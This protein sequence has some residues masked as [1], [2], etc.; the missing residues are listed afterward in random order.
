MSGPH[1][2]NLKEIFHG[3]AALPLRERAA[4]LDQACDGNESIRVA[5]ESLLKAHEES[6]NFVDAPAYLA[7]AD[8]LTDDQEFKMG[9]RIAHY[10]IRSVLGEGGMGKDIWQKTLS[11]AA[12]SG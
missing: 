2:E 5:V 3:A 9:E 1:W 4:Y 7:A 12:K 6:N 8:L 10:Q 11:W